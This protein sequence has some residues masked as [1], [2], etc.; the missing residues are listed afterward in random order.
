MAHSHITSA[1]I[2]ILW[3]GDDARS[4]ET[5]LPTHPDRDSTRG[6]IITLE[7]EDKFVVR[8]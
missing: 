6:R 2:A 8:G 4:V 7:F 3:N 1:G 5:T